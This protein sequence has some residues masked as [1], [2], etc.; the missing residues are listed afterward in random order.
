MEL[1]KWNMDERINSIGFTDRF[2]LVST[3]KS[4]V[5]K[6]HSGLKSLELSRLKWLNGACLSLHRNPLPG[7]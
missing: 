5:F 1:S 7:F 6:D 3:L 2:E 4:M